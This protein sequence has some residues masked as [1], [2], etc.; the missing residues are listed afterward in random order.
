MATYM[1]MDWLRGKLH[2]NTY[3]GAVPD[4]GLFLDAQDLQGD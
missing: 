1:H 2:D 4:A 3:Y